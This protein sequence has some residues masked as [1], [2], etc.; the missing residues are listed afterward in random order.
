MMGGG[1]FR[2]R[3]VGCS[4]DLGFVCWWLMCVQACWFPWFCIVDYE[5][6]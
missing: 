1:G 5:R 4:D 2:F 6:G 3:F